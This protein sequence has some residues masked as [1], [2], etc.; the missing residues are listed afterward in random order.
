LTEL[1]YLRM[2]KTY[3]II[4][5]FFALFMFDAIDSDAQRRTRTRE[6]T[7]ERDR[8][9]DEDVL[10]NKIW[11]G[12]N[13]GN[14]GFSNGG[15]SFSGKANVGYKIKDPFSAGLTSKFFYDV[16]TIQN[17][18]D[19]SLISY[20]LGAFARVKLIEGIFLHGEYN[21]SSYDN[22]NRLQF[23]GDRGSFTYPMVGGGYES[24]Y[25]DWTFGLMILFH[26]QEDVRE[27]S[28]TDFGEYWISFSYKF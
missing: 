27:L 9:A 5:L 26:I 19:I 7:R 25:G 12:F 3:V 4:S 16:I 18:S 10:Q 6:R 22:D 2:N 8:S 24:G 28:A 23:G 21:F 20:G 17:A 13:L 11:Y 14:F 1:N 15:F